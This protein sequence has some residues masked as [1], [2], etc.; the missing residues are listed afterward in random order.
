M[1]ATLSS[2][3]RIRCLAVVWPAA[4]H[5]EQG[6]AVVRVAFVC[7]IYAASLQ[8]TLCKPVGCDHRST[9][10]ASVVGRLRQ[11]AHR[12]C[13]S[14]GSIV[15]LPWSRRWCATWRETPR[16]QNNSILV[17]WVRTVWAK[18]QPASACL[19]NFRA[20]QATRPPSRPVGRG[21]GIAISL[22]SWCRFMG[23][24]QAHKQT[25]R[26]KSADAHRGRKVLNQAAPAVRL[27]L[28][29]CRAD[30]NLP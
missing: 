14:V 27:G 26:Q 21:I 15:D 28:V 30:Q 20:T 22:I 6:L 24:R 1:R 23:W 13:A 5:R 2:L 4:Q 25:F 8:E 29:L 17:I 18:L 3:N 19:A 10:A 9:L 7:Y 11:S 16:R 12:R